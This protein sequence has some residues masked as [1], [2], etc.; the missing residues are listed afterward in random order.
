MRSTSSGRSLRFRSHA[1]A[2]FALTVGFGALPVAC[3]KTS[4]SESER[5][6]APSPAAKPPLKPAATSSVIE[7]GPPPSTSV[8]IPAAA[9]ESCRDIC[10]RSKQLNC[11]HGDECLGNCIGMAT[12]TPCSAEFAKLLP[13]WLKEPLAHWECGDDGVGAIREGYCDK[14]QADAVACMEKKMQP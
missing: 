12:L 4:A 10:E 11:A 1:R 2:L 3:S 13:C 9:R 8:R 5:A 7:L 14:E 6:T